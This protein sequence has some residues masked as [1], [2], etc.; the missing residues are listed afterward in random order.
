MTAFEVSEYLLGVTGQAMLANDAETFADRFIVP[1]VIGTFDG[2]R[3]METRDD[4]IQTFR[5]VVRNLRQI[6][7]D[8]LVRYTVAAMFD[9]DDTDCVIATFESH[10]MRG[11]ESRRNPVMCHGKLRRVNGLWMVAESRYAVSS[12]PELDRVLMGNQQAISETAP[13]PSASR[14]Q[15][16]KR[17]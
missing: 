2:D 13:Y 3:V 7:A 15:C 5:G 9:G 8:R 17:D 6:G 11:Q 16:E 4:V 12:A 10:A 14:T 1:Q